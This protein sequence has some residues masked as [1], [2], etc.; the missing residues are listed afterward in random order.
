MHQK[1]FLEQIKTKSVEL[2]FDEL[3][4][5]DL[6]DFEFNSIKIKEFIDN[7]YHGEMYWMKDKI[8]I[9]SDPKNIWNE[10]KSA[11]VLGINYGPESNPLNDLKKV[12][13]GYISIYSRRKDYHKIIKSKLK[14][15]ARYVQKIEPSKVK[16][17]VDTAPLMEK[18][19]ASAAGLGWQG[20]HTNLVSRKHGSWLFLGVILTNIYFRDKKKIKSNCGSCSKC[21][22]VCPTQA[23]IK[24]Y[25]LDARRCISYLTIEHKTHIKKDFRIK[26]G[27]RIFGC[28][29]C[30]AVCPWNK[31][32][33][34]YR[35]IK[36]SYI[37]KL[38]MPNLKVFLS[39]SENDFRLY[40]IGTPIRRLG[41]NR[42]MRNVLIAAAN[43][44]DLSLINEVLKKLDSRNELIR[45]MAVWAL[46]CLSKSRFF[47]EK[48]KRFDT[49]DFY[50]V[51]QEWL[52][53]E[54]N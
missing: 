3:G 8:E 17:F 37:K 40:F 2:G 22:D 13:R 27:N 41:Y 12:K 20:K 4:I 28:D 24:P 43:S 47:L 18:P 6:K 19:L 52:N 7:N 26:I 39:F 5:T 16:V 33:K 1:Y 54:C 29:D 36:L 53:G 35:D 50:D 25:S 15:L 14:A 49:E 21:I 11:I 9:R 10:A 44:K 34:K 38:H 23:I 46:F 45:A 32:A 31:F 30:L 48:K 42:F 51:R